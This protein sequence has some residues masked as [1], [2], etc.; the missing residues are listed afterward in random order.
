MDQ[1]K[2]SSLQ[3]EAQLSQRNRA[4]AARL[5]WRLDEWIICS[6]TNP[7]FW[8]FRLYKVPWL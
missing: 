4:S 7:P 8:N 6:W 1:I 5:Q 2:Q 3:Q